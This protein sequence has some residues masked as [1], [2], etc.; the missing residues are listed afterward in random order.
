M[1]RDEWR[2]ELVR[3]AMQAVVEME[4]EPLDEFGRGDF[5]INGKGKKR[6]R[7]HMVERMEQAAQRIVV[8]RDSL[9]EA[10][11]SRGYMDGLAEQRD[12]ECERLDRIDATARALYAARYWR[13]GYT[14]AHAAYQE[15]E[16]LEKARAVWLAKR[17]GR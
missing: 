7:E 15:A 4:A 16:V 11:D 2:D 9:R 1:T 12:D 6:L 13:T 5:G 3:L 10:A 14:Q 8:E 17:G